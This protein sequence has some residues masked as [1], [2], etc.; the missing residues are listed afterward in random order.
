MLGF[1]VLAACGGGGGGATPPVG[2]T[3][4]PGGS[5]PPTSNPSP[6]P[7]ASTTPA[8]TPS[9]STSPAPTPTGITTPVPTPTGTA[10]A[11][12]TSN[13]TPVQTPTPLP[14]QSPTPVPTQSP[15]PVPTQSPTP[16][17]SSTPFAYS[18]EGAGNG[19]L[20]GTDNGFYSTPSNRDHNDGDLGST[21]AGAMPG[22]GGQGGSVDGTTCDPS[23]SNVYHVHVFVGLYVNGVQMA[24]PDGVGLVQ[25]LGEFTDPATGW[26][27]QEI[28][29]SSCFYHLHTHDP[30]GLL[31]VEDSDPSGTPI[32]GTLFNLGAFLDIWG[33]Q[34]DSGHFGPFTGVVTV[35]TSG[36]IA[37]G[38][39]SSEVP[40]S[41]EVGSTNYQLWTGGDPHAIPLYSHEVIWFEVG[42]GNP[43]AIHLPGINFETQQ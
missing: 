32:T 2:P 5:P 8:P 24:I 35:Y 7:T 40:G 13:P 23:M 27:N 19:N 41:C 33:V 36:Q 30:S 10:S 20:N 29:A 38:P 31:H 42:A 16:A 1:S 6:N 22:G 25:P 9:G 28:Y 26:K 18:W 17:P 15:T 21:D 43:D 12:P 39:C 4:N 34:V 14:T 3:N 37:R 11:S